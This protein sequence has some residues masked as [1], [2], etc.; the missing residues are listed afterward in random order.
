MRCFFQTSRIQDNCNCVF[1]YPSP[2]RLKALNALLGEVMP[3]NAPVYRPEAPSGPSHTAGARK[4]NAFARAIDSFL[5][6]IK[7]NEDVK[8]PFYKEVLSE[9]GKIA[10][11]DDSAQQNQ[12]AAQN[13]SVFIQEMD[14]RKRRDSKVMRFG[15]KLRPLVTGLAQFT[16]AADIAIQAGPSA[17]VVLYS[18]ARL[19]LQVYCIP[20][21]M[22]SSYR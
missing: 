11:Q 8:S 3:P 9:L 22:S 15:E 13:L 20:V 2:T 17:A 19:L 6:D 1:Y 21:Q 7:R 14:S 18:G 5:S 10:L 4:P 12:R 16:T